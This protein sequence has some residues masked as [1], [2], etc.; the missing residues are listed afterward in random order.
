MARSVNDGYSAFQLRAYQESN[1]LVSLFI[2]PENPD[3]FIAGYIHSLNARQV[4]LHAV[5][6]YGQYDG[7]IVVRLSD[8]NLVIGED[9][10]ALRLKK[11]LFLRD[12]RPGEAAVEALPGEDLT[13]ALCRVAHAAS[14]LITLWTAQAEY[15][16]RVRALDDIRVTIDALDFF[17]QD[18]TSVTLA[19]RDVLS[20]SL[21]AEDERMVELLAK[22]AG[23]EIL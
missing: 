1:A 8:V 18:P 23:I 22:H 17:G 19:L 15:C 3:D 11:L 4:M 13:H 10:Y 6:Q 14:H 12:P 9:E 2:D 20:T 16:G 7:Y 5:S 21:D